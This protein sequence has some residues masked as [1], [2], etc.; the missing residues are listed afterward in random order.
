MSKPAVSDDGQQKKHV[1]SPWVKG[2]AGSVGG[3]AEAS[4]CVQA[5]AACLLLHHAHTEQQPYAYLLV[6]ACALQ[7]MDVIKT[8]LQLDA[9]GRV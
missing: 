4:L 8:R 5:Q 6:Q 2:F 9:A 3:V 7:P 1:V